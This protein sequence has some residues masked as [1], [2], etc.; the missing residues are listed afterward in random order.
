MRLAEPA[1]CIARVA[2]ELN[3]VCPIFSTGPIV[4]SPVPDQSVITLLPVRCAAGRGCELG[5]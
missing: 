5:E 4:P 1:C 2:V 3:N